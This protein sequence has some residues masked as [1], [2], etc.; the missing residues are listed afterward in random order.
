MTDTVCAGVPGSALDS[1]SD[2]LISP[3]ALCLQGHTHKGIF[4]A[5]A[6]DETNPWLLVHHSLNCLNSTS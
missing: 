5:S 2:H 1:G 3:L 6:G 4:M